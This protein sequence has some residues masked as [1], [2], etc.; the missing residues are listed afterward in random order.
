MLVLFLP[1]APEL[2]VARFI[3]S[4]PVVTC[5]RARGDVDQ[6]AATIR[7]NGG[8]NAISEIPRNNFYASLSLTA[9]FH[10]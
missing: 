8:R 1:K 2:T 3:Y 7:D 9:N 5:H 10:P 4:G 6:S